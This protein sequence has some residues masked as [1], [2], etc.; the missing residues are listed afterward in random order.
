MCQTNWNAVTDYVLSS[1]PAGI[2][3]YDQKGTSYGT[4][5]SASTISQSGIAFTFRDSWGSGTVY[6]GYQGQ[7]WFWMDKK[8]SQSS[9]Y[10]KMDYEHTWSAATLQSFGI[11][12]PV[13]SAPTLD[14]NFVS[15]PY[16]FKIANQ[17]TL[18]SWPNF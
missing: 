18:Y 6:C 14:M 7:V 4:A 16:N 15:A 11:S 10:V 5:G 3:V 9:L 13:G 1:N 12:W 17:I 2:A 8:P